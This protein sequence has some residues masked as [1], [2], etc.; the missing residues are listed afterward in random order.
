MRLRRLGLVKAHKPRQ[1]PSLGGEKKQVEKISNVCV[2]LARH[3]TIYTK[4]PVTAHQH[5]PH[6]LVS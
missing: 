1:D 4:V 6:R 2:D 3:A 5:P